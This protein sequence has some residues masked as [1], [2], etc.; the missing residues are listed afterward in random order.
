MYLRNL[1]FTSTWCHMGTDSCKEQISAQQIHKQQHG[2]SKAVMYIDK[3]V[4]IL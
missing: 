4:D 3:A 1:C 2:K